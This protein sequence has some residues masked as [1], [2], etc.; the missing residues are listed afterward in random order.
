MYFRRF[1]TTL[2]SPLEDFLY[3]D[4]K[5]DAVTSCKI[6]SCVFRMSRVKGESKVLVVH[7]LLFS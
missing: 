5:K 2:L 7:M 6:A 4:T 1:V 3:A